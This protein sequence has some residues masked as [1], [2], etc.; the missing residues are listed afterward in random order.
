MNAT[1]TNEVQR[2]K[3]VELEAEQR[4]ETATERGDLSAA[5]NAEL[6]WIRASDALTEYVTLAA[7]ADL[8]RESG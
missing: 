7:H 6:D 2:L 1:T 5:R 3:A 4:Q 8:Y